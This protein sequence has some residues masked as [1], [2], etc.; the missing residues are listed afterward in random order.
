MTSYTNKL[1]NLLD[2]NSNK[3]VIGENIIGENVI[4]ENVIGENVIGENGSK[5]LSKETIDTCPIK[6]SFIAAFNGIVE[7][8]DDSSITEYIDN[9]INNLDINH[10]KYT[11]IEISEYYSYL[12][13]F[14]F[15]IR[16]IRNNGK[17]RRDEFYK[18][19]NILYLKYPEIMIELLEFCPDYGYWK[20]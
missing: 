7:N 9:I 18:L 4:G 19:F 5:M 12:Y 13:I 16:D 14:P 20:D 17:G 10:S 3:N 11:N 6:G 1:Y 2:F 8:T 15:L